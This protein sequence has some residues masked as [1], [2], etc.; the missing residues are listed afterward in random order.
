MWHN[1]QYQCDTDNDN[2]KHL[3]DCPGLPIVLVNVKLHLGILDLVAM[4]MPA[5]AHDFRSTESSSVIM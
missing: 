2:M 1:K 5:C 3:W 4:C